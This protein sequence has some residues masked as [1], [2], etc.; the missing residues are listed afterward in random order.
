MREIVV[1]VYLN[2]LEEGLLPSTRI[3]SVTHYVAQKI[4]MTPYFLTLHIC[5][6]VFHFAYLF[7]VGT[8][9]AGLALAK[10][11]TK[12]CSCAWYAIR[13]KHYMYVRRQSA[14]TAVSVCYT[15]HL[16]PT[17]AF[18]HMPVGP[19]LPAV[20]QWAS[21]GLA[22]SVHLLEL[23]PPTSALG[24]QG[25]TQ[26]TPLI[27]SYERWGT[28]CHISF[29]PPASTDTQ[30]KPVTKRHFDLN[31]A[32]HSLRLDL[33]HMDNQLLLSNINTPSLGGL[34]MFLGAEMRSLGFL[35]KFMPS[36][37]YKQMLTYMVNDALAR[38]AHPCS[39]TSECNFN[40]SLIIFSFIFFS[41]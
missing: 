4:C 24:V 33:K 13:C 3:S 30:T 12:N 15:L 26:F 7:C 31:S 5:K 2:A 41:K 38:I 39:C 11:C 40:W 18:K 22:V 23:N 28:L 21:R 29:F 8:W 10:Q 36:C 1:R 32:K 19:A 35:N 27:W 6:H 14:E 16:D 20:K 9:H 17:S 37:K 25:L 34:S